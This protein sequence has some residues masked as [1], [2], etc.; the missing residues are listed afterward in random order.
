MS[1]NKY[2]NKLPIL[3]LTLALISIIGC[4]KIIEVDPP[5][6][7]VT[8]Q[9]VYTNDQ[10]ATAV[11]TNIYRA[12]AS[13]Y[14]VTVAKFMGLMSDE[15]GLM[16]GADIVH[17]AYY[18]NS[19]YST[20]QLAN[21]GNDIWNLSYSYLFN[22][23][24]AIE[25]L[26][27]SN[28]LTPYV[29]NQLL[30]EAYF[31][32]AWL[33]FYLVNIYGDL[34]IVIATDPQN[35][36]QLS[37]S[38]TADVYNLIIEDLLRA[39][40]LLNISFVDGQLKPY[41]A[42]PERVRPTYWA[43]TALLAR[44]Y[45]YTGYP[46]KAEMEASKVINNREKFQLVKYA[47]VF[48]KNSRE[49]IWQ[50]QPI[51]SGWNAYEGRTFN[52][53]AAPAGVSSTK[54]VFLSKFLLREFDMNDERRKQWVDS[55]IFGGTTYYFPVKYKMGE[56]NSNV[57]SISA[58]TEYSMMLRLGELYLIR[59]EARARQN[60]LVEAVTDVDSL[61]KRASL[62]LVEKTNPSITQSVLLDT[63]LHERQVELFS[64]WG[65]RWLDLIRYGK[66][67]DVMSVVTSQKGG[68][69]ENTDVLLPIP[70]YDIFYNP[71]L[72]QNEGY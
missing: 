12:M 72:T 10:T 52:L 25:G 3:V 31:I 46:L 15:F 14:T 68:T 35:N 70:F 7:A 18:T 58:L 33:Y 55:L 4:K 57:T 36:R 64:E 16:S 6:N 61:R 13:G 28:S 20:S 24:S 34:P 48:R 40:E 54:P 21:T 8:Q 43:A 11:L 27:A 41:T 49:A 17:T 22:C 50:L 66:V 53:G 2:N 44:V 51:E 37:R 30:G 59:A 39:Q 42:N 62:P 63:V 65:H 26:T 45:L 71:K 47:D 19:L 23:N 1:N 56:R 60:N 5:A 38:S 69:W 67:N 29:K 32:R 9:N